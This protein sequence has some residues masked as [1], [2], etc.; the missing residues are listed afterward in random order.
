M[1][2]EI[3]A[4][5]VDLKKLNA[6]GREHVFDVHITALDD[7][8]VTLSGRVLAEADRQ[9]LRQA[10]HAHLPALTVDDEEVQTLRLAEPRLR[11]VATNLTSL[12]REPSWL[13]EQLSQMLYGAQLE[14]LEEREKWAYVCCADGYLGWAYL[15]Y[16]TA[17]WQPP[18]THL[19]TAP[20]SLM[21]AEPGADAEKIT[22]VLGGTF[23]HML[24]LQG[25][26][27]NIQ[28]NHKGWVPADDLRN[29]QSMPVT[30]AQRRTQM[31]ADAFRM[32]GVPYLWGGSSALGIDCSGFAQLIHRW[33]GITL[34][35]DA[36]MQMADG[37]TV[38]QPQLQP[39]DLV[40]FGEGIDHRTITHVGISLG[41]WDIIH[42]SRSRNGVY[43]DNIQAVQGLRESFAGGTTYLG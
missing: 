24:G 4:I 13:A 11:F 3:Q 37:K 17:E 35:R 26:W 21:S 30:T 20:V 27:A 2:D 10:L 41:G 29:L 18:A 16:M 7:K 23:V 5:L 14:I 1:R 43:P 39:G 33:S 38:E 15:P 25:E 12:H 36:D 42:S 40:F 22:R 6:D 34:R 19:V 28:A 8:Q 9:A 32:V 31:I